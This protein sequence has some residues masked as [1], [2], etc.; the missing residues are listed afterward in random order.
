MEKHKIP[1]YTIKL[2]SNNE[3]GY[4]VRVPAFPEIVTEGRTLSEAAMAQDAIAC[5]VGLYIE[6]GRKLPRDVN[7]KATGEPKYFKLATAGVK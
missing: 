6:E 2:K 3:G 1:R 4:I 7:Y 5:C